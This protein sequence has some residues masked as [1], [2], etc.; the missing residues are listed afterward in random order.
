MEDNKNIFMGC[1]IAEH[2]KDFSVA[3]IVEFKEGNFKIIKISSWH[4]SDTMVTTGK[5]IE[6]IKEYN[7]DKIYV[8]AI[9]VGKG[10]FDRLKEQ[11]FKAIGVK[12]GMSATVDKNRF[13]NKKSQFYWNL[14][15]LFENGNISIL[16]HRILIKELSLMKYEITSGGKI[17]IIDPEGKS[18]DFADALILA[19][20]SSIQSLQSFGSP[21]KIPLDWY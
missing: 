3:T 20:A 4:K 5:I 11:K 2:G 6:L 14:R 16:N 10:V 18:P 7:V 17:K 9:G 21:E 15:N 13:L 1:D 19:C 8:D 12:V